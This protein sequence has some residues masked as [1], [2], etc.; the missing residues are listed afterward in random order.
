MPRALELCPGGEQRVQI[1]LKVLG[2][3]HSGEEILV[4]GPK[5][6]IGRDRDCQLRPNS[7]VI[8]RHH[9]ALI[10]DQE[11]V[12]VR[13]FNSRNGTFVDGTQVIGEQELHA[14]SELVIGPLRFLVQLDMQVGGKKHSQVKS[15]QEAAARTSQLA[16]GEEKDIDDWLD[17]TDPGSSDTS[18]MAAKS[19]SQHRTDGSHTETDAKILSGNT[20][21]PNEEPPPTEKARQSPEEKKPGKLP[22]R[23]DDEQEKSANTQAAVIDVLRKLR[24]KKKK[25]QNK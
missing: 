12:G 8:S 15:I 10:I 13:D 4:S 23:P 19:G 3:S 24:E 25:Q 16:D 22:R 14:G 9:C 2:G 11:Y 20:A 6:F 21:K 1:R 18:L 7:D 5:F 17:D